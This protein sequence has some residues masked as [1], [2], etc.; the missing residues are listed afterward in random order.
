MVTMCSMSH[1]LR[2]G[3][4]DEN[5]AITEGLGLNRLSKM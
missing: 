3:S 5:D 4:R 2:I 1:Q